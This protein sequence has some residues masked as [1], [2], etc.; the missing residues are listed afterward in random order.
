[1]FL[2]KFDPILHKKKLLFCVFLFLHLLKHLDAFWYCD[3][4]VVCG[5]YVAPM[6]LADIHLAR[7]AQDVQLLL[8][9][10][11]PS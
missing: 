10:H 4:S 7:G 9:G 2:Q 3:I 1:L 6:L 11:S 5:P 8:L